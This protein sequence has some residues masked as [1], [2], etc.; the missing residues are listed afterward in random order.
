MRAA[1]SPGSKRWGFETGIPS[2]SSRPA[3]DKAARPREQRRS[4]Q[5]TSVLPYHRQSD[6]FDED[7]LGSP[8]QHA[9]HPLA[10]SEPFFD[11]GEF[12]T[13]EHFTVLVASLHL[14]ARLLCD[15]LH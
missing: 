4:S 9:G 13:G 3:R 11:P 12:S 5:T 8:Q 1:G 15:A 7:Q 2:P 6:E 14:L 10:A